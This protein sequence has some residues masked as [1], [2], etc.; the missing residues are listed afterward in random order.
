MQ[1]V[2]KIL[3][4]A[5]LFACWLLLLG[6]QGRQPTVLFDQGHGQRF[7]IDKQGS[8]H[9]SML[10]DIFRDYGFT[11]KTNEGKIS[12]ETLKGADVLMISGAFAP[13]ASSEIDSLVDFVEGG[14]TLCVMLHIGQPVAGLLWRFN[15][16]ISNGVIREQ[17]NLINGK[18]KDFFITRLASHPLMDGLERFAV[19][20]SWALNATDKHGREKHGKIIAQTSSTAWIDLNRDGQFNETYAMQSYGVVVTGTFGKG[21]FVAF[22]DDAIFQNTFLEKE[23]MALGKNLVKWLSNSSIMP[24]PMLNE[25]K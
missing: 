10:A 13:L 15:V 1:Y 3:F 4:A 5:C 25:L 8:L 22:G 6:L 23:N 14:G 18:Q 17:E 12:H 20:G 16:L 24:T 7:L 21:R 19:H 9:L 2:K 11:V